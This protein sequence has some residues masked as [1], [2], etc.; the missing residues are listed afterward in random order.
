MRSL[1]LWQGWK[2]GRLE[3]CVPVCGTFI[4]ACWNACAAHVCVCVC[5]LLFELLSFL[6]LQ[7]F[8][9]QKDD[10]IDG[11]L[12]NY[13]HDWVTCERVW[14][15]SLKRHSKEIKKTKKIMRKECDKNLL[16]L[17]VCLFYFP[18]LYQM[19]LPSFR[20]VPIPLMVFRW[21]HSESFEGFQ[22]PFPD[23]HFSFA[24]H[25]LSLHCFSLRIAYVEP[26]QTENAFDK[27]ANAIQLMEIVSISSG[28]VAGFFGSG[29]P[30]YKLPYL[31][32]PSHTHAV[33][34]HAHTLAEHSDIRILLQRWHN[35]CHI[36][37]LNGAFLDGCGRF[38]WGTGLS[39][40]QRKKRRR[41]FH[42]LSRLSAPF[43][44][45]CA[46]HANNISKSISACA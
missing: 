3:G 45:Y 24:K 39:A 30:S 22:Q 25:L 32:A 29:V 44:L 7:L 16:H 23:L 27:R 1:P 5:V 10:C 2:D 8:R 15:S 46:K 18:C 20:S 11:L 37:P 14:K 13:A 31:F 35:C 4:S 19:T 9:L 40:P 36:R 41:E 34:T 43:R 38:W 28:A 42:F 33:L 17:L 6:L 12:L 26:R 21:G